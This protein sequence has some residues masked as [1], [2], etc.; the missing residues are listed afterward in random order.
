MNGA[1]DSFPRKRE[2]GMRG[3]EREEEE[4]GDFTKSLRTERQGE[5]HQPQPHPHHTVG[6]NHE[7]P[8]RQIPVCGGTVL[9]YQCC[10]G[11]FPPVCQDASIYAG[12]VK[13]IPD[14]HPLVPMLDSPRKGEKTR[15]CAPMH[16]PGQ[17][18]GSRQ[19]ALHPFVGTFSL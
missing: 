6:M 13:S 4:E 18:L 1:G 2:E 14:F 15:T 19:A 9:R 10:C 16:H 8:P 7:K 3:G 12:C 17:P 5:L 11:C